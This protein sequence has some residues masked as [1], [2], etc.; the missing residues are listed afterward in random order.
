MPSIVI[1]AHN[2][3]RGI[4]RLLDNLVP[5]ESLDL[6]IVVVANGC[7]DRTAD[8]ARRT[9]VSVIESPIPSKA[10]AL[11]L[12]D[13]SVNT[14]PRLY[15]DGDVVLAAG[16]V[17]HLCAGLGGSVHAVAPQ[18][19]LRLD[20]CAL[21][22]RAYYSVWQR[23]P[24]VRRELYGRGV[25]AVDE[26]GWTRIQDWPEVMAD[27]LFV[28]MSFAPEERR[29]LSS[30]KVIIWP[31]RNY[32][33]LLLRRIRIALGNAHLSRVGG[34]YVRTSGA[35]A[36]TLLRMAAREPKLAPCVLVF[37]TTTLLAR[38]AGPLMRKRAAQSWL[39]DESSRH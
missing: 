33:D 3:E 37:A 29:V 24:G 7:T 34:S 22:V 27:D 6:E 2:E 11:A 23:L 1:P 28:A 26:E 32:K 16:D 30:A 17:Q 39:R 18:R 9:G 14:F 21:V 31:P 35:S 12:G 8:V 4:A 15:V 10:R 25:L 20:K 19:E 36:V 5:S 38:V 13:A